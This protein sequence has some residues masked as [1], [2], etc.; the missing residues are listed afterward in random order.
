MNYHTDK[1]GKKHFGDSKPSKM[2]IDKHIP[3]NIQKEL[4]KGIT[5]ERLTDLLLPSCPKSGFI[6]IS[7]CSSQYNRWFRMMLIEWDD[8]INGESI[9][10]LIEW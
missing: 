7:W 2:T 1:N 8:D 5:I 10:K 4:K 9:V 3:N 6:P